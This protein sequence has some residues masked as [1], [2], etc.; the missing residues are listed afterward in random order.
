MNLPFKIP[1]ADSYPFLCTLE[2][3][4]QEVIWA[5]EYA[6]HVEMGAKDFDEY[7]QQIQDHLSEVIADRDSDSDAILCTKSQNHSLSETTS[8]TGSGDSPS[9]S[10]SGKSIAR[11]PR[12]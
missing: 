2:D 6:S 12:I 4:Y 1:T 10:V 5:A 11:G 7:L 9:L 3:K 8:A